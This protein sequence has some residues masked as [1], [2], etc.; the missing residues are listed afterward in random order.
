MFTDLLIAHNGAGTCTDLLIEHNGAGTCT[1]LLIAH[2][3]AGTCTDLLIAHN[4]AATCT[5]LLIEQ[6]NAYFWYQYSCS[7]YPSRDR[8]TR[9]YHIRPYKSSTGKFIFLIPL[10]MY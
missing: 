4:G 2:N 9:L 10:F 5:D 7:E 8:L 6:A 3:G 1:D